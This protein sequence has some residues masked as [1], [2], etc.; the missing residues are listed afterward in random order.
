MTHL[1]RP[2]HRI[3][4]HSLSRP[5]TLLAGLDALALLPATGGLT[6]LVRVALESYLAIGVF[7]VTRDLR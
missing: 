4:C 5:T 2:A 6:D 1:L 7:L 3:A